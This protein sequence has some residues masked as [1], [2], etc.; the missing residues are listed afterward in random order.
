M[1]LSQICFSI[2]NSPKQLKNIFPNVDLPLLKKKSVQEKPSTHFGNSGNSFWVDAASR[3][4]CG[5]CFA[6]EEVAQLEVGVVVM[7]GMG[8]YWKGFLDIAG[9]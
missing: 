7:G 2:L 1:V 5:L 9:S 6:N 4:V 3:R 8:R